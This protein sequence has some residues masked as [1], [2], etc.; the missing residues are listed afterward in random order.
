MAQQGR[1][2]RDERAAL[3]RAKR[4]AWWLAAFVLVFYVGYFAWN[5]LR[6]G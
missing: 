1:N 4:M 6:G 2:G 5:A 3:A